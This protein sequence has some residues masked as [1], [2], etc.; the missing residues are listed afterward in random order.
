VVT[1]RR[2]GLSTLAACLVASVSA[3]AAIASDSIAS[4]TPL[5]FG[6]GQEV[7]TT[8]YTVE[9]GEQNTV[10]PFSQSC[11]TD[12]AVGIARTAWFSIQGTGGAVTV[13]TG[14]SSFDTS[15]FVYSESP[16]G[17]LVACNDDA[18]ETTQSSVGFSSVAGAAYAVQ[19]GSFCDENVGCGAVL[20]GTLKIL[21]TAAALPTPLPPPGPAAP[22]APNTSIL[23]KPKAK[24]TQ[25]QAK[26]T[27]TSS[28]QN[29]TFEC[30]LDGAGFKSCISPRIL[31]AGKGTHIFRV[32]S[33]VAGLTDQTPATYSW[34]VV[35]K[36]RH[37]HR[38]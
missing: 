3:P 26:F 14:G 13:T 24:T 7:S 35:R 37:R 15:L 36:H 6:T 28:G 16:S 25:T 5:A 38:R 1:L 4:P 11:G 18:G 2:I 8:A 20:G 27:F 22:Q 12:N 21:A 32:R 10:A 30:S 17:G 34:K 29:A 9:S 31:H 19:A 23:A 33:T